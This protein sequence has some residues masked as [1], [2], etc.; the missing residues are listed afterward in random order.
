[1]ADTPC[2]LQVQQWLADA[3]KATV[4]DRA[5]A[6]CSPFPG[7]HLITGSIAPRCRQDRATHASGA[8]E[9]AATETAVVIPVS[10]ATLACHKSGSDRRARGA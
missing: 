6:A 7:D 10:A 1:L 8:T 3:I 4:G 2:G 9:R 5:D